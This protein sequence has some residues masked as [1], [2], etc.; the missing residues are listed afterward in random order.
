M[1][2]F[3]S[4]HTCCFNILQYISC[5]DYEMYHFKNLSQLIKYTWFLVKIC[6]I[7]NFQY[8]FVIELISIF[9]KNKLEV[10]KLIS[11]FVFGKMDVIVPFY[12]KHLLCQGFGF[13]LAKNFIVKSKQN[14]YTKIIFWS[15]P[16]QPMIFLSKKCISGYH[17]MWKYIYFVTP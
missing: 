5:S 16:A 9:K 10:K 17:S 2:I 4:V 12:Q 3:S 8:I 14:L 1:R 11:D 7:I 13:N 15:S 6:I